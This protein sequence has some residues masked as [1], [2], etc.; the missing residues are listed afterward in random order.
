VLASISTLD[1]VFIAVLATSMLL[2]A[3]RGLVYELISVASWLAAFVAAQ[4]FAPQVG[5]WLPMAGAGEQLRYAAGFLV[6]FIAT[7]FTGGLLAFVVSKMVSAVGLGPM[8]RLLGA[9]FGF[10]RGGILLLS[11]A[12]LVGMTPAK[13]SAL[14]QSSVGAH[15]ADAALAVLKPVLPKEFGK[16]LA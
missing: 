6:V 3:W 11:A 15:M 16:Y 12:I 1:W 8:D 13:N 2:G 10:V 14:W 5:H 7:V 4:W 9:C